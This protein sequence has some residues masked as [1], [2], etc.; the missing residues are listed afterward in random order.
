VGVQVGSSLNN[1]N[2]FYVKLQNKQNLLTLMNSG[3]SD[4]CITDQTMFITYEAL[5]KPLKG[6]SVDKG[7]SFN[8]IGKG[9]T[10]LYT[11]V[12]RGK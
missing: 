2:G 7:S 9:N 5:N 4:Y 1:P 10:V 11:Y 12:N 6:L 3:A 8:I